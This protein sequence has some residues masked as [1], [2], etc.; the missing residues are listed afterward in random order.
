M[1]DKRVISALIGLPLL[2]LSV[3]IS[4]KVFYYALLAI[5][6]I[7][8]YEY[9]SSIEKANIKPMKYWGIFM[10]L[11]L[12]IFIAD[13]RLHSFIFPLI[14]ISVMILLSLPIFDR[15]YNFIGAGA[16]LIGAFYVPVLFSYLYL[17]RSIPGT[18]IYLIWFVFIISWFSD[19]AAY[20][21]GRAFG[22]TKL[23]PEVSPKKTVEG[24]VGGLLGSTIGCIIYGYIL[25]IFTAINIPITH[26]IIIGLAGSI[27]S[28][29][30]DLSASSI[31]R[32]AGVKDYGNIMP[33]HGGVLDRFD[34]ILFVAPLIYYYIAYIL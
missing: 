18:G 9:F 13:S 8:L 27:I 26:L 10:G 4:L 28:M 17:I 32:N 14:T 33:G 25:K 15:R 1:L 6:F 24:A 19:T 16:A 2:F 11:L 31:K 5:T 7:G 22:K 23:C 21:T 12:Y 34:S 20:Y 30:G 3:L 29:L